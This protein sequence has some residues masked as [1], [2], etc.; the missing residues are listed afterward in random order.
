[1]AEVRKRYM[2]A[3][4]KKEDFVTYLS[5]WVAD[6]NQERSIMQDAIQKHGLMPHL[7]YE[8][9][10]LRDIASY[11]YDTDFNKPHNHIMRAH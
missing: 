8:K 5:N 11:I 6:P 10:V 9:E 1:M 7:G 4:S 3:F 2:Q